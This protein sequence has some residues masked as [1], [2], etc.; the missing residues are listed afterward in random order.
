M[1][2]NQWGMDPYKPHKN[3]YDKWDKYVNNVQKMEKPL[4]IE[5]LF[6]N[7]DR[8]AIGFEPFF[9]ALKD[10]NSSKAPSYPPYNVVRVGEN[11]VIEMAVA[12]LKKE[13]LEITVADQTLIIA[14]RKD[15]VLGDDKIEIVNAQDE[16]QVV[17]RGIASRA[18]TVKF[19]LSEHI[20]VSEAS[21]EDGILT[22]FC[23]NVIPEE[24]KPK[25]IDIK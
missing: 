4:T 22:I 14:T 10:A 18:F 6:P 17:H 19:A 2:T 8:W 20:V 16:V 12:G 5:T 24:K 23:N 3:P 13:D 7:M 21:L 9:A 15:A 11:Y 1:N 25:V